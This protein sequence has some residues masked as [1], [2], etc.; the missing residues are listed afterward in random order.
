MGLQEASGETGKK[1]KWKGND[2][3]VLQVTID[4]YTATLPALATAIEE[5]TFLALDCEMTGLFLDTAQHSLLD[6]MP[7]RYAKVCL[8]ASVS[9][10]GH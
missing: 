4:N 1:G 3:S 7:A 2:A 8:T 10:N 6:D 5:S 9:F